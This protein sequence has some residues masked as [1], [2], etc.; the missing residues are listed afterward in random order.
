MSLPQETLL[1]LM[2]LAD[3]ELEGEELAR[4][5]QLVASSPE[6]RRVVDALGS[7]ALGVFLQDDVDRHAPIA[8]TIADGVMARIDA[9]EARGPAPVSPISIVRARKAARS[10]LVTASLGAALALAAGVV[11]YLRAGDRADLPGAPVASVGLPPVDVQ[12]APSSLAALVQRPTQGVEVDEVDSPSRDISVFEIPLA[13]GA[14]N[15]KGP[16]SVVITIDDD[17][18]SK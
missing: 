5:E 14:A 12:P 2:A 10:R 11:L 9:S 3:G 18:G 8:D 16:S 15:A 6:A 1:Q 7:P 17:P 13:A 4:V